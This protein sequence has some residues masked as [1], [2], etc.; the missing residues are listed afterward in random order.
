MANKLQNSTIKDTFKSV[1]GN[2]KIAM[3]KQYLRKM[4]MRALK[5][6]ITHVKTIRVTWLATY[7][8]CKLNQSRMCI[9][10]YSNHK[11]NRLPKFDY[12]KLKGVIWKTKLVNCRYD[13]Y[14]VKI[15][16]G[17][18]LNRI[19]CIYLSNK[20]VSVTN[21]KYERQDYKRLHS[22]GTAQESNRF[23]IRA[24]QF[25]RRKLLRTWASPQCARGNCVGGQW[26]H[27]QLERVYFKIDRF[28]VVQVG[29]FL[30]RAVACVTCRS[31]P[32]S[33]VLRKC[34]QV[35]VLLL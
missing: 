12:I 18:H 34:Q 23:T 8:H 35:Q 33:R 25:T 30:W 21:N 26:A 28:C 4:I 9:V 22:R 20:V 19:T 3:F 5:Q 32:N 7:V 17:S 10:N 2:A 1:I 16:R 29:E 11:G 6:N 13:R 14:Y 15:S 27:V 31:Q 24:L